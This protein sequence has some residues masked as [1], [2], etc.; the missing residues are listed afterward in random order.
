MEEEEEMEQEMKVGDRQED[1]GVDNVRPE[2]K[3]RTPYRFTAFNSHISRGHVTRGP[4]MPA[5]R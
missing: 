4:R 5:P 1:G 3:H 2:G